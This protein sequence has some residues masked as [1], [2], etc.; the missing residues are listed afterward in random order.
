MPKVFF[1]AIKDSVMA[2]NA[3]GREPSRRDVLLQDSERDPPRADGAWS[4][5]PEASDSEKASRSPASSP[6]TAGQVLSVIGP[7]LAFKGHL[8]ADEDL[9]IQGHIEGSIDHS[10]ANLTIGIHGEVQGNIVARKVLIQGAVNGDVRASE[11][12]AV[13][14][15]ARMQG[16]LFAPRIGLKDGARFKGAIEMDVAAAADAAP[17]ASRTQND[18]Q[19]RPDFEVDELL[20]PSS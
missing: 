15:S 10:G 1:K 12:I 4:Q 8:V 14:A 18:A 5:P 3:V 6:I 13:E 2:S 17:R 19:V 7:S 11:T 9:L 20:A 16:N